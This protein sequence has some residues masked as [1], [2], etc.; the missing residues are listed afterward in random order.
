MRNLVHSDRRLS[1]NQAYYE[2]I[3]KRLHEAVCRK[4]LNFGP[5]IGFSP[6][7]VLQLIKRCQAVSGQKTDYSNGT[8]I[9]FP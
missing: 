7:T 2:E 6:M 8:P 3:L 9:V 4:G 1:F 5:T